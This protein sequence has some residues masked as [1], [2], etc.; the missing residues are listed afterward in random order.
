MVTDTRLALAR[1]RLER[2]PDWVTYLTESWFV[3]IEEDCWGKK[4]FCLRNHP[5]NSTTSFTML[6]TWAEVVKTVRQLE[7]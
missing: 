7:L 5:G 3:V 2:H 6:Y 1:K 4:W